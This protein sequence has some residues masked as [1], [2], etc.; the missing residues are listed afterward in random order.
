MGFTPTQAGRLLAKL[1]EN[2]KAQAAVW[3][4]I[5][6]GIR[7]G[8]YLAIRWQN[9]DEERAVLKI[10]EAFYR[11]HL[12]TPKTEASIR[13]LIT[14]TYSRRS[15]RVVFPSSRR[16]CRSIRQSIIARCPLHDQ[17]RRVNSFPDCAELDLVVRS[18]GMTAIKRQP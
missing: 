18:T 11:G 5:V 13:N 8:E 4:L 2:A 7:R 6:T 17:R 3:L 16:I 14:R 10:T 12:D 15:L 9:V 1:S